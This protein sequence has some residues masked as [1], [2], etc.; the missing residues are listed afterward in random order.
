MSKLTG[1]ITSAVLMAGMGAANAGGTP[2]ILG[3]ADYQAMSTSQMST[4][5]GEHRNRHRNR[6]GSIN[7]RNVNN[8]VNFN[9]QQQAQCLAVCAGGDINVLAPPVVP[10][11]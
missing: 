1:F 8:N 10:A 4:I 7:I 9:Q 11:P 2:E 6:R 5:T 3:A